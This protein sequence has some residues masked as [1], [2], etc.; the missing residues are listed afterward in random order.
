[1]QVMMMIIIMIMIMTLIKNNDNDYDCD[2]TNTHCLRQT[3]LLLVSLAHHV[4]L[5]SACRSVTA[6][7]VR[8]SE[9]AAASSACHFFQKFDDPAQDRDSFVPKGIYSIEEMKLLGQENGWCPYFT[10]RYLLRSANVVV[11]NRA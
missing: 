2:V 8:N 9:S 5:P 1:M 4:T 3:L 7:W 10:S 11:Y 6:S